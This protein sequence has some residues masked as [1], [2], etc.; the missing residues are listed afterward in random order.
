MSAPPTPL[1]RRFP[2]ALI[3]VAV[4]AI[5]PVPSAPALTVLFQN[6]FDS[7]PLRAP[8]QETW[9]SA[10]AFTHDPPNGWDRTV[11]A[12]GLNNS[13]VGIFEWEGWSF[14]N[15]DFWRTVAGPG[16]AGFTL[17]QGTIAVADPDRW[18]DLGN[19]ADT[20]GFY[21]TLMRTR[22]ISLRTL[23][24]DRL[25]VVFDSSWRGGCCDDGNSF[26]LGGNNQ[27]AIVNAVLPNGQRIQLLRWE[28]APFRTSTGRPSMTPTPF[29]NPFYKPNNVNERVALDLTP[30]VGPS[31]ATPDGDE[32][33]PPALVTTPTEI[34]LEFLIEDAGDDGWWA[35]DSIN[36]QSFTTLLGDMN[37]SGE[38][39]A[40]DIHAFALGMLDE[41][42]YRF[43]YAGEFPVSHGSL[44]SRFDFDDIAWFTNLMETSGAVPAAAQ[45]LAAA[46]AP[47]PE[48]TAVCLAAIG[49][50]LCGRRRRQHR[51]GTP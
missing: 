47:V 25:K 8:V 24:D 35:I 19:P 42:A 44:D 1:R 10:N 50:S 12:P 4:V 37:L 29:P 9:T 11:Q 2:I 48:P 5:G 36:V 51:V 18:N 26:D 40:G 38:L 31:L 34:R 17:G 27:T 21:N 32:L 14:A 6:N 45:A 39:E 30:L 41:D 49:G 20:L 3:G 16:R 7:L 33:G 28:S 15:K 46:L 22:S 23:T 13:Q 43:A